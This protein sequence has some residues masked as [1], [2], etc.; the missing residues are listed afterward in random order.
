M[1]GMRGDATFHSDNRQTQLLVPGG[2]D[3]RHR[4]PARSVSRTGLPAL[5]LSSLWK[6]EGLDSFA[7]RAEARPRHRQGQVHSRSVPTPGV[8][9]RESG[10]LRVLVT[11]LTSAQTVGVLAG[12]TV[13]PKVA[14][15]TLRSCVNDFIVSFS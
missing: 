7:G 1:S 12:T 10:A 13:P 8:G 11:G 6:H 2:G 14:N 9:R 15:R 3:S 4:G 5:T